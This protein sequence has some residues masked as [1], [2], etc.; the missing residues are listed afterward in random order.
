MRVHQVPGRGPHGRGHP[1]RAPHRGTRR[2]YR[3]SRH[4]AAH[5][6]SSVPRAGPGR[7]ALQGGRR[8]VLRNRYPHVRPADGRQRET[9][10]H[11]SGEPCYYLPIN[12]SITIFHVVNQY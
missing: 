9:R 1:V 4:A 7:G 5:P 12:M 11:G 6:A 3:R 8:P 2:L 10:S